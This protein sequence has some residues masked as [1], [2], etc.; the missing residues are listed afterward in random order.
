M[1]MK[2]PVHRWHLA[3]LLSILPGWHFKAR[4]QDM[5]AIGPSLGQNLP[6]RC[7]DWRGMLS[8]VA[9]QGF[10]GKQMPRCSS[11]AFL[12]GHEMLI[13]RTRVLSIR[14][15]KTP[16][17]WWVG[18]GVSLPGSTPWNCLPLT[19]L[20]TAFLPAAAQPWS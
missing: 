1:H 20:S 4:A 14:G 12:L 3:G 7:W 15:R 11:A 13:E 16:G 5:V 18:W 17:W 6:A 10:L 9:R 8:Q 2:C 19:P